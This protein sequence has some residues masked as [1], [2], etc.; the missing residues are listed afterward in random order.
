MMNQN[1]T[2][3]L[4]VQNVVKTYGPI[5]ALKGVS[6]D[7]KKGEVFGLLG[8]NGAG[9]T[10]LISCIVTLEQLTAGSIQV[11]GH[12]PSKS[13]R[14][15]KTHTGWVPQEV[16]NH[17]Y[18]SVEEILYFQAGYYGVK[19]PRERI[20]YLLEGLGLFEHRLKKVKQL[21]GGMKRRL[22]I[23]K[24][25]IHSPG[26][27]LLDEPTAGVDVE[28]RTRLWDFVSQLRREG[29]SIL[30]TTHYLEEA[31]HLCDRVAII[32]KGELR[33]MGPTRSLIEKF[34]RKNIVLELVDPVRS[35]SHPDMVKGEGREW[36]FLTS[37]DKTLGQL[38]RELN[39]PLDQLRDVQ[40]SDGRL[41]D[42]FVKFTQDNPP[43]IHA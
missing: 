28:L 27:L 12:D 26:L 37:M 15:A 4:C 14:E 43:D 41:E 20:Q 25:L 32:H 16:I 24:A 35:M 19:S 34:S 6:F 18:F 42:V 31:E 21:S 11:F 38:L 7:V 40:V 22:M 39:V 13:A 9:K 17:G 1:V 10:S 36:T 2:P 33:E 8:P 29:L 5:Q 3:A 30:L 23:A